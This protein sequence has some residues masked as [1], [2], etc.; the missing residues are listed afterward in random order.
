MVIWYFFDTH[1]FTASSSL[2]IIYVTCHR[3]FQS[4]ATSAEFSA[5]CHHCTSCQFLSRLTTSYNFLLHLISSSYVLPSP[6]TSSHFLSRFIISQHIRY[7]VCYILLL[8]TSHHFLSPGA[9]FHNCPSRP[10]LHFFPYLTTSPN[11]SLHPTTSNHVLLLRATSYYF[12][13]PEITSHHDLQL[14]TARYVLVPLITSFT[15]YHHCLSR[16]TNSPT[17]SYHLLSRPTSSHHLVPLPTTSHCLLLPLHTPHHTIVP[18]TYSYYHW[19]P[20]ATCHHTDPS[21]PR[22]TTSYHVWPLMTACHAIY[23]FLATFAH[24]QICTTTYRFWSLL[25]TF[26]QLSHLIT[27]SCHA[28]PHVDHVSPHRITSRHFVSLLTTYSCPHFTTFNDPHNVNY[29]M[30]LLTPTCQF[31][32]S[33]FFPTRPASS[34]LPNLFWPHPTR[35]CIPPPPSC[36]CHV[37]SHPNHVWYVFINHILHLPVTSYHLRPVLITYHSVISSFLPPHTTSHC[38]GRPPT[39]SWHMLTYLATSCD[40]WPTTTCHLALIVTVTNQL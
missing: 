39:R 7:T 6:T 12:L 13:P 23:S 10:S 32:A 25:T 11:L 20:P 34:A 19:P 14:L 28:L 37:R 16:L 24:W 17:T 5:A 18:R 36:S 3:L 38:S 33:Y 22:P 9:S 30:S 29:F 15:N 2:P 40:L 31:T 21:S 26:I 4:T 35:S 8:T 1:P 27:T